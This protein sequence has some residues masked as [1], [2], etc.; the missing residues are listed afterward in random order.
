[1][2]SNRM[3]P[4]ALGDGE[5]SRFD[6]FEPVY[7]RIP[8]FAPGL[9]H[10]AVSSVLAA[11]RQYVP[12]NGLVTRSVRFGKSVTKSLHIG[13]RTLVISWQRFLNLY[14]FETT[15]EG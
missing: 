2:T 4:E 6:I 11:L 13:F 8:V 9:A 1:M 10:P 14:L 12:K 15:Q 5:H 3:A 7:H